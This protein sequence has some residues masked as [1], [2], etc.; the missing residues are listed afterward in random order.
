MPK[1]GI[2]SFSRA[3]QLQ[4][5]GGNFLEDIWNATLGK[6]FKWDDEEDSTDLSPR[7]VEAIYAVFVPSQ[8]KEEEILEV[9]P[10]LRSVSYLC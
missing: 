1:G 8:D 2:Q 6:L 3:R 9:L 10:R 5:H 7:N 4:Q